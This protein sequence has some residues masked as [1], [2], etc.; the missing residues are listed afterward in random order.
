MAAQATARKNTKQ[1]SPPK[2][3]SSNTCGSTMNRSGGPAWVSAPN[4][5]TA[6]T[7]TI[8]DKTAASVLNTTTLRADET[9][10]TFFFR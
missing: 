1:N 7:T 10:F 4:A 9:T 3:I 2:G 8:A 5:N 6:G